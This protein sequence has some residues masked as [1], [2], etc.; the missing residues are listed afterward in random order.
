MRRQHARVVCVLH[1]DSQCLFF[2]TQPVLAN[3][4]AYALQAQDELILF[5]DHWPWKRHHLSTLHPPFVCTWL[6]VFMEVKFQYS[7]CHCH[8]WTTSLYRVYFVNALCRHSNWIR[9]ELL[10]VC[11]HPHRS[12]RFSPGR[13]QEETGRLS[14]SSRNV[15]TPPRRLPPTAYLVATANKIQR[16]CILIVTTVRT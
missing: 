13:G 7:M 4:T 1:W 2:T 8:C 12:A 14:A 11:A 3:R 10:L 6:S 15:C 16:T 5:H 9:C